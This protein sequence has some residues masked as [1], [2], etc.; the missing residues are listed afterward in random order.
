MF[1]L[2]KKKVSYEPLD[3]DDSKISSLGKG[4]LIP[5]ESVSDEMFAQKMLGDSIAFAFTGNG[6]NVFAPVNG[7]LSVMFPTGHAFGITTDDGVEVLVH[8]GINTVAS[9]GAGFKVLDKKQG[10]TVKAGD[11]VVAVDFD[12]LSAQYDMATMLII[13]DANGKTVTLTREGEVD[14]DTIVGEI[15]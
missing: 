2:F 11:P 10:D 9:K 13:T 12:K 3:L 5:I 1:D 6:V 4:K 15:A 8:I 14:R 7:T